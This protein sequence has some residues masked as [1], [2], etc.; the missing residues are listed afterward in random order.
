MGVRTRQGLA[1]AVLNRADDL[2]LG[3]VKHP[4]NKGEMFFGWALSHPDVV[5]DHVDTS[6]AVCSLYPLEKSTAWNAVVG[7]VR[8]Q[9]SATNKTGLFVRGFVVRVYYSI[10]LIYDPLIVFEGME[11]PSML[12]GVDCEVFGHA[13]TQNTL[14]LFR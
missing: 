9:L 13:R 12:D 7:D 4:N 8:I 6:R 14:S 2:S 10:D 3:E 11:Q 5:L 1:V